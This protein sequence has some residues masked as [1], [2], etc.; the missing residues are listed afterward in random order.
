MAAYPSQPF[1]SSN[2]GQHTIDP[3]THPK[4]EDSRQAR[5]FSWRLVIAMPVK[6]PQSL[7]LH[8]LCVAVVKGEI[9]R[10]REDSADEM[11]RR[12][13]RESGTMPRDCQQ[14]HAR[15]ITGSL[16]ARLEV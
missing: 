1:W 11:I 13:A 7:Q 15:N 9:D 8:R 10:P 6:L 16:L 4:R 2:T 5:S 12:N 14:A 3:F